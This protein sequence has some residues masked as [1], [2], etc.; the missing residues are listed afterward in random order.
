MYG[1]GK[2]LCMEDVGLVSRSFFFVARACFF[3]AGGSLE[4]STARFGDKATSKRKLWP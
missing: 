1:K 3:F 2:M 4:K